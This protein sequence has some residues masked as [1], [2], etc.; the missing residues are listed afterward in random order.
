[1][2][3]IVAVVLPVIVAYTSYEFWV[4]RGKVRDYYTKD[5]P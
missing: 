3:V 5:R 4:F 2:L 1:M